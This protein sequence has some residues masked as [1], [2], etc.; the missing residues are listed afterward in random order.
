ML[1]SS[2]SWRKTFSH[3]GKMS[4]IIHSTRIVLCIAILAVVFGN[5]ISYASPFRFSGDWGYDQTDQEGQEEFYTQ[6]Y[7]ASFNRQINQALS[8]NADVRYTKSWREEGLN[9]ETLTPVLDMI[10]ANDFFQA[11]LSGSARERM[12]DESADTSDRYWESHL[13]SNWRKRFFPEMR[14]NFGQNIEKN[15]DNPRTID[16]KTTSGNASFDWDVEIGKITYNY[17]HQESVNDVSLTEDKTSGHFAKFDTTQ[18]FLANRLQVNFSQTYSED[19]FEYISIIGPSGSQLLKFTLNQTLFVEDTDLIPVPGDNS[20]QLN[21]EPELLDGDTSTVP[22]SIS[23]VPTSGRSLEF[24][25][26]V[27]TLQYGPD[28]QVDKVY[29]Y[30]SVDITQPPLNVNPA[31]I[32]WSLYSNTNLFSDWTPEAPPA[33]IVYDPVEQRFEFDITPGLTSPYVMLVANPTP[34]TPVDYFTE[35][36]AYYNF[37]GSAGATFSVESKTRTNKTDFGLNYKFNE[38]LKAVYTLFYETR[39]ISNDVANDVETDQSSHTGS[40]NWKPSK[41]FDSMLTASLT[42]Q[43]NGTGGDSSGRTYSFDVTSPTL[44]TIDLNYGLDRTE[45]YIGDVKIS[46]SNGYHINSG[47]Q[48]YEDLSA[49]L[50]LNYATIKREIT[51]EEAKIFDS[52]LRLTSRFN[53]QLAVNF[54]GG[55]NNSKSQTSADTFLTDMTINWRI[56]DK[57]LIQGTGTQK[58]LEETPDQTGCNMKIVLALTPK[59]QSD[60]NYNVVDSGDTRNDA[61]MNL[62]WSINKLLSAQFDSGYRTY[63]DTEEWN[64]SVRVTAAIGSN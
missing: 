34:T 18:F 38:K 32:T 58:W 52:R 5:S 51:D 44:P 61:A 57:L 17:R 43:D 6:T 37:S 11:G 1:I 42:E 19:D 47:A 39:D 13:S 48:L 46:S 36:E 30:T 49:S 35:I 45:S 41:Y 55:Y 50:D 27:N 23:A 24:A 20:P 14:F 64:I 28:A 62:R 53:P 21:D 56:S 60:L 63:N 15:D 54:S 33:L 9:Q 12:G 3:T 8:Y 10:L 4:G 2:Q 16:I 29:I 26:N 25:F 31:N 7:G 22:A 40:L 59:I